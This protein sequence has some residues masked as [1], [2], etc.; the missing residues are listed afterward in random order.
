MADITRG[1]G[2]DSPEDIKDEPALAGAG[3]DPDTPVAAGVEGPGQNDEDE[4]DDDDFD[5]EDDADE[6]DDEEDDAKQASD[7]ED[8]ASGLQKLQPDWLP[9]R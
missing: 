8:D 6:D 3:V 9:G 5:E 4:E 1:T 7:D 2:A